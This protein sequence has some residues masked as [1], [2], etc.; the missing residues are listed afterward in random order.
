MTLI[1]KNKRAF[2]DYKI[3]KEFEA[4]MSLEGWEVKSLNN[5]G[6]TSASISESYVSFEEG[7]AY[8]IESKI[9]PMLEASTHFTITPNRKR[10]LLLHKKEINWLKSNKE[11]SSMSVIPLEIYL[12]NRKLKVK[13]ALVQ[14]KNTFDKRHSL[15]EKAVN[16]ESD[17]LTKSLNVNS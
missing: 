12:L 5:L 14:G 10:K 15:K 9:T 1:L 2:F 7:E 16:M 11:R 6:D 13:V 8:L 4:G 17:K 3:V